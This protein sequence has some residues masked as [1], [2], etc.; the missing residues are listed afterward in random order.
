[1]FM[2]HN[3]RFCNVNNKNEMYLFPLLIH[4]CRLVKQPFEVT[5]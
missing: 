3:K 1:M 4:V 2:K 5:R